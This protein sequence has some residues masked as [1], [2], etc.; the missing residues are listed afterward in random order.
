MKRVQ[1]LAGVKLITIIRRDYRPGNEMVIA[2]FYFLHH[3]G[4]WTVDRGPWTVDRATEWLSPALVFRSVVSFHSLS[5][6]FMETAIQPFPLYADNYV[7]HFI[8]HS[9]QYLNRI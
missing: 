5:K 2:S 9:N 4:P 6:S 3:R 1:L 7:K 8:G